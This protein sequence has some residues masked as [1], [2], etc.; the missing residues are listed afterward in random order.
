MRIARRE[1]N[2]SNAV[3]HVDSRRDKNGKRV[4]PKKRWPPGKWY[5][6]PSGK[7]VYEPP[8]PVY[9]PLPGQAGYV[10]GVGAGGE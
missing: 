3:S 9:R 5:A 6:K 10:A 4:K 7:K 1:K 8:P 2:R